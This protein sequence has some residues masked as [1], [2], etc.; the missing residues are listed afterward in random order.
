MKLILMLM[1]TLAVVDADGAANT[2]PGSPMKVA[3][4]NGHTPTP[5]RRNSRSAQRFNT[6]PAASIARPT[7]AGA[8]AG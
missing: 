5:L 4:L 2:T 7:T 6:T 1:L 8:L 3:G